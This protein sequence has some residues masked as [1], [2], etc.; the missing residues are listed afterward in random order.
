[1][2]MIYR[3]AIPKSMEIRYTS[4]FEGVYTN[5]CHIGLGFKKLKIHRPRLYGNGLSIGPGMKCI[6]KCFLTLAENNTYS[7]RFVA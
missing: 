1:M 7:V 6:R 5:I 2:V 3:Y 4:Q